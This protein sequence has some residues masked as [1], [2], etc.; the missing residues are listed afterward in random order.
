MHK[1]LEDIN[2]FVEPCF[3]FLVFTSGLVAPYHLRT[4]HGE[5]RHFVCTSDLAKVNHYE[6]TVTVSFSDVSGYLKHG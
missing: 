5:L 3:G 1:F 2:L 6:T 4:S